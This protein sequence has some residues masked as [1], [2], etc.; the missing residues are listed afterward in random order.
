RKLVP[1]D[2]IFVAESGIKTP[3]DIAALKQANVDAVLIGETFM[4]CE[5]KK[6]MLTALNGG[7]VK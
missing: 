1:N 3:Q 4:R 2:I 7:E 6:E 5:N